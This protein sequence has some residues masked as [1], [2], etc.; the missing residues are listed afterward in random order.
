MACSRRLSDLT[1]TPTPP[2]TSSH[3]R[4][5]TSPTRSGRLAWSLSAWT[6]PS[7][8]SLA[9]VGS[10]LKSF[11]LLLNVYDLLCPDHTRS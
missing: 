1:A 5:V 8:T 11:T 4:C 10:S 9:L 7:A 3:V 2:W 6:T